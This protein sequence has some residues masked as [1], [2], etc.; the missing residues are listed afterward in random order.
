MEMMPLA[1]QFILESTL[2]MK[3]CINAKFYCIYNGCD[4]MDGSIS[5]VYGH[6]LQRIEPIRV[7]SLVLKLRSQMIF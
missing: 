2:K 6:H 1:T 4:R 7:V 5:E 3:C